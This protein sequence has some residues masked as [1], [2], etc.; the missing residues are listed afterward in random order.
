MKK[1]VLGCLLASAILG[2]ASTDFKKHAEYAPPNLLMGYQTLEYP[3]PN[4]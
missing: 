2:L 4:I 1:F 3:P